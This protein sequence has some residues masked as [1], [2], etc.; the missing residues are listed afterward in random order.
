MNNSTSN[1]SSE[2]AKHLTQVSRKISY[3][4]R[5]DPE[6]ENLVMAPDGSVDIHELAKAVSIPI[7]TL[8]EIVS[9][10]EKSRYVISGNRIWAAQ[11][12][13]IKVD[14]PLDKVQTAGVL[15]H[16]TSVSAYSSI[17]EQGLVPGKREWVHLSSTKET[18][19]QVSSRRKGP[20]VILKI[21]AKRMLEEG[22]ELWMASNGV[23]LTSYVSPQFITE[24]SGINR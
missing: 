22:L 12:H 3:L 1:A 13:S 11:G 20:S 8:F 14:L 7:E 17:R 24:D 5:H 21:D 6:S 2:K 16:G 9:A 4:L 23:I 18:A 10:D 19:A 15:Y